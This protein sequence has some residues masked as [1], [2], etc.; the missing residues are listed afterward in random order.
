[1]AKFKEITAVSCG[2]YS[3]YRVL[4]LFEDADDAKE[5]AKAIAEDRDA[6]KSDA[7]P[8][9][10]VLVPK[11][12]KPFKVTTYGRNA[13]LMDNGEIVNDRPYSCTE[14][15]IEGVYE[16]PTKRPKV[17]YVRA[18]CHDNAGGRLEVSASSEAVVDK[19][20]NDRVAMWRVG[21]F[22]GPKVEEV[23]ES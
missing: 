19:A 9:N 8:E 22:G 20:F 14:W 10:F 16:M 1:M 6:W 7:A 4:A 17:R 3:D 23:N 12:T 13:D 11:G 2:S 15:A 21:E 18:P 5:W